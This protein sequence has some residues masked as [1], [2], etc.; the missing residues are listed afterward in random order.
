[1]ERLSQVAS[2][3][4]FIRMFR[5]MVAEENNLAED[6][7]FPLDDEAASDLLYTLLGMWLA[8]CAPAPLKTRAEV[9][10]SIDRMVGLLKE[11][12]HH[13]P[14]DEGE[15]REAVLHCMRRG[16]TPQYWPRTR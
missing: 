14:E 6:A 2:P 10:A 16:V 8:M 11:L 13:L 1:M 5:S 15:L 12:P 4:E 7:I 3:E 9:I